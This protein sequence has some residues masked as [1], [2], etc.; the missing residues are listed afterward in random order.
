MTTSTMP[1]VVTRHQAVARTRVTTA[2]LGGLLLFAAGATLVLVI[3]TCEA[4]YP[5]AYSTGH[6]EISDLGGTRPP[7]GLVF[8]PVATIF[9]LGM[10]ASGALVLLGTALAG[11][12]AR[13]WWV[14]APLV[15][16]GA[17]TLLVGI[18]PGNTGTPHA[19]AAMVAFISGGIGA[20]LSA[21]VVQP[22]FRWALRALGG[23]NLL[24][25]AS[26]FIQGDSSPVWVLG[27]GGAERWIVYPVI[28]WLLGFGGYLAGRADAVGAR[29]GEV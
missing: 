7:N 6:N 19:I 3:L 9:N 1:A 15:V 17:S 12:E 24:F 25:L 8:Q 18:F 27:V 20:V 23:I 13:R 4:L 28:L 11:R 14:R 22:P 10:M 2:Q 26:Y 21:Q 16:L 29:P 5:I